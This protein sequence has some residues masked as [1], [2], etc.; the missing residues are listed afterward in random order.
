VKVWIITANDIE[1]AYP[2]EAFATRE[3]AAE[4]YEQLLGEE[5]SKY[6]VLLNRPDNNG[7]LIAPWKVNYFS[8]IVELEVQE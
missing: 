2:V 3:R 5:R 6:L 7:K 8:I 4:R 1:N